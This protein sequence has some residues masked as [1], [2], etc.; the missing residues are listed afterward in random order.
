[1]I[2]LALS[3]LFASA[4]LFALAA[5]AQSWRQYGTATLAVHGALAQCDATRSFSYRIISFDA[6]RAVPGKPAPEKL[7]AQIITLPIR[8]SARRPFLLPA[9][10][11][12]A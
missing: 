7:S 6:T 12:A 9:L 2:G 11:A 8:R 5:I 10:R 3:T 1:M 4:A